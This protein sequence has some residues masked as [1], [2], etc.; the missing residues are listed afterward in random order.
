MGQDVDVTDDHG[1]ARCVYLEG[2]KYS[3]HWCI[4]NFVLIIDVH[5]C[6][7][8]NVVKKGTLIRNL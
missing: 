5:N 6:A 4:L 8:D 7:K 3:F 1:D 2:V